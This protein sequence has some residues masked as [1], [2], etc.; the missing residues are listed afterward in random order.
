MICG[1]GFFPVNAKVVFALE[2][3]LMEAEML[4]VD[5]PFR[6]G[7]IQLM[8]KLEL[9][10]L[11]SPVATERWILLHDSE[12]GAAGGHVLKAYDGQQVWT[13]RGVDGCRQRA[14]GWGNNQWGCIA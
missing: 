14:E 12:T 5:Q 4:D 10:D 11:D 8:E 2:S 13:P 9:A 3:V 1:G 7:M 6:L